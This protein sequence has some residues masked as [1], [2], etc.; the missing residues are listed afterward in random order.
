MQLIHAFSQMLE[1]VTK[2]MAGWGTLSESG[3]CWPSKAPLTGCVNITRQFAT[4]TYSWD[5]LLSEENRRNLKSRLDQLKTIRRFNSKQQT[6]A[7]V[8]VPLCHVNGVLSVLFTVRS[9]SLRKHRGEVSFP[10]G[11]VDPNDSD[12]VHTALREAE[13]EIGIPH[14][15]IDVMA[16]MP[17]VADRVRKMSV[18]GVMGYIGHIDLSELKINPGEVESVFVISV[19][20]LC[21]PQYLRQTQYRSTYYP[22]GYT[23]P[24][25]VTSAPRVWGMTAIMLHLALSSLAPD[26]Y[27]HKLRHIA[28]LISH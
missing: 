9:N 19:E 26:V 20:D 13:E 21:N 6:G 11:M 27:K 22:K 12:V 24:A 15:S 7:S 4:N 14:S 23:L 5:V 16:T 2:N 25:F 17:Q 1:G 28:P 10:G 8:L 18:Q 3:L